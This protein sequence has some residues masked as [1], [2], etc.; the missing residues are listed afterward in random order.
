M[1]GEFSTF[2]FISWTKYHSSKVLLVRAVLSFVYA[3]SITILCVHVSLPKAT[4]VSAFSIWF[5]TDE[6][7]PSRESRL[8]NEVA[9]EWV[10]LYKEEYRAVVLVL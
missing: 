3:C 9:L 5:T 8:K 1:S 2:S 7:L 10:N 6:K 4:V